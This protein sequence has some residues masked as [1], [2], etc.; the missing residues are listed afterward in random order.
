MRGFC[1][2]LAVL[3]RHCRSV[4]HR[5]VRELADLLGV[6]FEPLGDCGFV[7]S[8]VFHPLVNARSL[9]ACERGERFR[10]HTHRSERS[11]RANRGAGGVGSVG[12]VG[13]LR[14]VRF[15]FGLIGHGQTLSMVTRRVN[16]KYCVAQ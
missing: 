14:G 12:S 8:D 4:F 13:S 16:P 11:E 10:G 3:R 9:V 1:E 6:G 2:L 7:H 15:G 5:V